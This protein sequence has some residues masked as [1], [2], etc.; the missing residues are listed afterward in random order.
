MVHLIQSWR[1]RGYDNLIDVDGGF[2]L[3]RIREEVQGLTE[4][5]FCHI[6]RYSSKTEKLLNPKMAGQLPC[7][8]LI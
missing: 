2:K 8:F 5:R 7:P 4:L 6:Q 1:A 3:L